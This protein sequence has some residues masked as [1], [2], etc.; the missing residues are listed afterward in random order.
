[1]LNAQCPVYHRCGQTVPGRRTGR[2]ADW[3]GELDAIV[4]QNGVDFVGNGGDQMAE[5]LGSAG[6]SCPL[7]Q[8]SKGKLGGAVNRHAPRTGT[9]CLLLSAPQRCRMSM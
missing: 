9:A 3:R 7:V 2:S 8:F 6:T 5:E 4:G 1:M